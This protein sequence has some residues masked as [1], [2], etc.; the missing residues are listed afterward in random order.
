MLEHLT[1]HEVDALY[2]AIWY[3]AL[4]DYKSEQSNKFLYSWLINEG[5]LTFAPHLSKKKVVE[6]INE[7]LSK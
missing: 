6:C 7:Y 3:Q 1:R 4:R 5:R 2:F